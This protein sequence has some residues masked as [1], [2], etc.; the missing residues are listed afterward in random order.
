[1]RVFDRYE[2]FKEQY[3]VVK[4]ASKRELPFLYRLLRRFETHR[5]EKVARLLP[6]GKLRVLEVGCGDGEFLYRNKMK[7]K[8]IEGI[9]VVDSLIKKA[10]KREYGVKAHFSVEDF[11]LQR[12]PY[13]AS[14]FDI[15][16]CI[17][18]LQYIYDID[19]FIS[20]CHRVLK[21]GGIII[22]EV[23]NSAVF[24]KRLGFLFGTFPVTTEYTNKWDGGV[25]HYFTYKSLS[26]FF[27]QKKFEIIK[28]SCSG[29]FDTM[30]DIHPGTLGADLIFVVR[31]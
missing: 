12:M 21:P 27:Q 7:W 25:I 3:G 6:D 13:K 26:S 14:S 5:I 8:S 23:P 15:V 29:I 22:C 1:M 10:Q 19:A 4:R 28:I 16:V 2:V 11:G 31:K 9:D 30:R 20:E 24:W 17:A 18:T